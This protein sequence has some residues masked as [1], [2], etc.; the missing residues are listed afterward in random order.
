[1]EFIEIENIEGVIYGGFKINHPAELPKKA[2][3]HICIIDKMFNN[4]NV[5]RCIGKKET[6][7]FIYKTKY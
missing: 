1:M 3:L 5:Y 7:V 4:Y 6:K 2:F